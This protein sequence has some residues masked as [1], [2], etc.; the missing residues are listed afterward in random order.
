MINTQTIEKLA[1][2]LSEQL[3]SGF[4]DLKIEAEKNFKAILQQQFSKLDLVTR[5]EFDTQNAVLLRTREKLDALEKK[6]TEL[7]E[8]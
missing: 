3:P 4:N 2:S 5:E 1:K 8:K 6:I 7:S